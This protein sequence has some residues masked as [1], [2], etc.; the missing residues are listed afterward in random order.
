MCF[1]FNDDVGF[2]IYNQCFVI[3]LVLNRRGLLGKMG[4]SGTNCP[5]PPKWNWTY[6]VQVIDQIGSFFYFPSLNFQRASGG[7][8]GL[9][10]N[11]RDTKSIPFATP[12]GEV[13]LLISDWY[14]QSHR[15]SVLNIVKI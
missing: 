4:Y 8:G 13:M 7:F 2:T 11:D 5:I 15:V 1:L 10:I 9:I 12:D 6:Q 14:T 3:G